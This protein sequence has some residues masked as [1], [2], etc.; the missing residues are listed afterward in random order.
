VAVRDGDLAEA[1][2]ASVANPFVFPEMA[3]A[4]APALDPGA[5]RVSATPIDAVALLT[6][7]PSDFSAASPNPRNSASAAHVCP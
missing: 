2:G 5:D 1:V 4:G 6:L 7:S 3:V